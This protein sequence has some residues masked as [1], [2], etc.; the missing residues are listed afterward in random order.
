MGESGSVVV[1]DE[2]QE[3]FFELGFRKG[4]VVHLAFFQK[5]ESEFL[6][7]RLVDVRN[8]EVWTN[9]FLCEHAMEEVSEDD[10]I[11]ASYVLCFGD[12]AILSPVRGRTCI[13][14][15]LQEVSMII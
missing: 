7:G 5:P 15:G 6:G 9:L 2:G 1:L 8:K 14:L 12:E 13:G 3:E 10:E 11:V 4:D